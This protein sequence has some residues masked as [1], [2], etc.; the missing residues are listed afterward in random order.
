MTEQPVRK[1]QRLYQMPLE[2][3]QATVSISHVGVLSN[4]DAE[5]LIA[6]F[7]MIIKKLQ[8]GID[9]TSV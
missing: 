1:E 4:N 8:R 6:L 7:G 9:R 2:Q 3:G 5:D